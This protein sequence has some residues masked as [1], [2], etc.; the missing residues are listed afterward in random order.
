MIKQ[1]VDLNLSNC[2]SKQETGMLGVKR[3]AAV[4][5]SKYAN[6]CAVLPPPPP[7]GSTLLLECELVYPTWQKTYF[8]S[9]ADSYLKV[10]KMKRASEVDAHRHFSQRERESVYMSVCMSVQG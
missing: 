10:T 7:R 2:Y 8:S 1:G 5:G 3:G 4:T 9:L 6:H